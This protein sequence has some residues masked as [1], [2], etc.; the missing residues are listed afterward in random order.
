MDYENLKPEDLEDKEIDVKFE[1]N[2]FKGPI[3]CKMCNKKMEN[4]IL[5]F[6]LSDKSMTLHLNIYKCSKCHKEHLSGEQA[7][8][9]DNMLNLID[10]IKKKPKFKF[11]R[12]ANFD[13]KNWFIRFPTDLTKDWHKKKMTDIIPLNNKDFFIHI[14]DKKD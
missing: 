13:G 10:V 3:N 1:K 6:E 7:E 8:K 11:E 2:A 9:F 5:D 12:A 14:K 4:A